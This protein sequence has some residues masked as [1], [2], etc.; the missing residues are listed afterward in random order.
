MKVNVWNF[1]D[2]FSVP[3]GAG[4]N[5]ASSKSTSS[6]DHSSLTDS[7]ILFGSQCGPDISQRASQEYTIP[8]KQQRNSQYNSQD[9]DPSMSVKYQSKPPLYHSDYKDRGTFQTCGI[10][11]PRGILEQFEETKRKAKE[12]YDNDQL[13]SVIY[14]IQVTVEELKKLIGQVDENTNLSYKSIMEAV[15]T[16][17][18]AM[19]GLT[20][21]QHETL[22]QALSA[23]SSV[24]QFM[25]DLEKKVDN[26]AG[27]TAQLKCDVQLLLT[28]L[29][30]LKSHK[31]EEREET[32][33]KLTWFSDYLKTMENSIL[34]EL[35]KMSSVPKL[36]LHLK[37]NSSQT[38]PESVPDKSLGEHSKSQL[39]T[40][41]RDEEDSPLSQ[42]NLPMRSNL[43]DDRFAKN[44]C[45]SCHVKEDTRRESSHAAHRDFCRAPFCGFESR[46]FPKMSDSNTFD[47]YQRTLGNPSIKSTQISQIRQL[48]INS[49]C[50]ETYLSGMA[51]TCS[52]H[53][54]VEEKMSRRI[55]KKVKG[56]KGKKR[57][58]PTRRKRSHCPLEYNTDKVSRALAESSQDESENI[59]WEFGRAVKESTEDCVTF[60]SESAVP[61]LPIVPVPI[62]KTSGKNVKKLPLLCSDKRQ[63]QLPDVCVGEKVGVSTTEQ[64]LT[65]WDFAS[66]NS[67]H[68]HYSNTSESDMTWVS[69]LRP[70]FENGLNQPL[71]QT[72]QKT[73]SLCF[74]SS[75]DSV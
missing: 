67:N 27:E 34:C 57:K 23:K 7:Q 2:M 20:A 8:S 52:D 53:E 48:P 43:S 28:C 51:N 58:R 54:N 6:S 44:F 68:L 32:S 24:E 29:D 72:K 40:V 46:M 75:E 66:E 10:G 31:C 1:K 21:S 56:K 3:P 35:Q 55:G 12:K 14:N 42:S 33:K 37:D 13:K 17:S 45:A 73:F 36:T 47:W 63:K 30:A 26:N 5:K 39:G 4:A 25:L 11:K 19:Q 70:L 64:K 71:L 74:D 15:E 59:S 62:R 38:S 41:K 18:N 16:A 9:S 50:K 69:P 65:C 61:S 22:L 60:H 49:N